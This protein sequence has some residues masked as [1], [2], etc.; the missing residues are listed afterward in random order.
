MFG[1]NITDNLD[2]P[3][4]SGAEIVD[5]AIGPVNSPLPKNQL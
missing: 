1:S 3:Q 4:L 2:A 5:R